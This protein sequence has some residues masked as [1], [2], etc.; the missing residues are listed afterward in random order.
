MEDNI[1]FIKAELRALKSFVT[2]GLYSL[3]RIWIEKGQN[4]PNQKFWRKM[5]I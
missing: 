2:G 1:A 5:Q 4:T 3:Y